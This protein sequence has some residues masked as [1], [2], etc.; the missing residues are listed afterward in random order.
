[1]KNEGNK[2]NNQE[3]ATVSLHLNLSNLALLTY[4]QQK[5]VVRYRE[6]PVQRILR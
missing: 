3:I 2:N 1:M 6:K 5:V 4:A